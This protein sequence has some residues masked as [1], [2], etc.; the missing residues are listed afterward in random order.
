MSDKPQQLNINIVQLVN[1]ACNLL[2]QGFLKQPKDKAKA[3]LKDLKNGKRLKMGNLTIGEKME[4]P[5]HLVLDYSEFRGG[6]NFPAFEAALRAMLQ[7]ISV[8]LKRKK[9]LNI[10][11][12][13]EQ[14][15]A[16]VHLP[17]VIQSQDGR[18]N[19]LVMS[20]E[21]GKPKEIGIRVMFVDPDQYEQLKPEADKVDD[22]EG[23]SEGDSA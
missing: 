22:S 8:Q 13:E 5:L 18:Y 10:L 6:F 7:R 1:L 19:V 12:N 11:T 21:M 23:D 16:L 3:L 9:D 2:H 14:G 4:V 20:F 17:G 15:S